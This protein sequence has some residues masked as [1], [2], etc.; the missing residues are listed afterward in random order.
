M[1][2]GID[3]AVL[4]NDPTSSGGRVTRL[5]M[6]AFERIADDGLVALHPT[7]ALE[8]TGRVEVV[9]SQLA[10][11]FRPLGRV[12]GLHWAQLG[13]L[14]QAR[15]QKVDLLHCVYHEVPLLAPPRLKIS[16]MIHDL[17]G[18]RADCGYRR[19][20]RAHFHHYWRL[21][22]ASKRS[23]GFLFVS[24]STRRAFCDRF[25]YTVSR[26]A[27]D[28]LWF[29]E[30]TPTRSTSVHR[31]GFS[32]A[33]QEPFFT[34]FA[35]PGRRKGV[36]LFARAFRGY[37]ERGGRSRLILMLSGLS[38]PEAAEYFVD[39]LR[40]VTFLEAV[41]DSERDT[42]IA[43]SRGL[44]FP[45]RCE[46]FGL[47]LIEALA[48][49]VWPIAFTNTPAEE[50]L[51]RPDKLARWGDTDELALRMLEADSE[52][53]SESTIEA[54][55]ARAMALERFSFFNRE[56]FNASVEELVRQLTP[57]S[58]IRTASST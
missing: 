49:G 13:L 48:L 29:T 36:D 57:P 27:V 41:N 34:G 19:L 8:A 7:G 40:H 22:T 50:I 33:L 54:E 43:A 18:L 2:I 55:A 32:Q 31:A 44:V 39:S 15:H 21:W 20:G 53:A 11:R 37:V 28:S 12:G 26:P 58:E 4:S 3:T 17:C 16:S 42:L 38:Q 14:S 1:R 56:R 46:G 30:P 24:N 25:P 23:D 35:Y 5:V 9:A 52:F 45:S 47:P 51:A 6:S 10:E